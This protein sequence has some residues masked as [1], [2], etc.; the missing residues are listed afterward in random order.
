MRQLLA[1]SMIVLS[2]GIVSPTWALSQV[3]DAASEKVCSNTECEQQFKKL[4]KY[5]R[6]GNPEAQYMVAAAY[7]TGDGLEKDPERGVKYLKK[8]KLAGSA[9]ATWM[10]SNLYRE[11]VGVEQDSERAAEL[12]E[13]AV[14]MKFGPAQF[15]LAVQRLDFTRQ[16]NAAGLM[17]LQAS[18]ES[19][20]KPAMYLMAKMYQTGT[21]VDT[22]LFAAAKLYSKLTTAGYR[23]SQSRLDTI[24]M[25]AEAWP[26]LQAKLA[27]LHLNAEVIK[28]EGEA[29]T[30]ASALDDAVER[31]SQNQVYNGTNSAYS[32]IKGR[33]CHRSKTFCTSF[34][35]RTDN[36]AA[37][38]GAA[39]PVFSDVFKA[40]IIE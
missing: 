19:Q 30:F 7:L 20:Y 32:R 15:Q 5:A 40:G 33:V 6:Y 28:V 10:L 37:L 8:A 27:T 1:P 12:L 11:G 39:W 35:D 24:V 3:P 21:Q 16:D 29:F 4:K 17:L 31:I 38:Q 36:R 2:L 25:A 14:A 34:G 26:E 13:K 22:D 18:V 23:D 9:K